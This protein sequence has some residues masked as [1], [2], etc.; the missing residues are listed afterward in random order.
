MKA[1]VFIGTPHS[2]H[3]II[4]DEGADASLSNL[5]NFLLES[6]SPD[7]E[8]MREQCICIA[9]INDKFTNCGHPLEIFSYYEYDEVRLNRLSVAS[10]SMIEDRNGKIC[11]LHLY[12]ERDT[13]P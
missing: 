1:I 11:R 2:G 10:N 6:E 12:G 3:R 9:S 13:S 8:A 7:E 5:L 4:N